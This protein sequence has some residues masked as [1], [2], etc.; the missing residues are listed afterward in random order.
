M[1]KGGVDWWCCE[2]GTEYI[3]YKYNVV[4]LFKL[5]LK[6]GGLCIS[7]KNGVANMLSYLFFPP[8]M[9]KCFNILVSN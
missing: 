1:G 4:N 3:V 9:L 8:E 7:T 2:N 6:I 5:N